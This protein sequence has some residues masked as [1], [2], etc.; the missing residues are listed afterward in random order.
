MFPLTC[1]PDSVIWPCRGGHGEGSGLGLLVLGHLCSVPWGSGSVLAN[2]SKQ[3]GNSCPWESRGQPCILHKKQDQFSAKERPE[4]KAFPYL[5]GTQLGKP[6]S[7]AFK[8][9][10]LILVSWGSYLWLL[11]ST[12]QFI[13]SPGDSLG[14]CCSIQ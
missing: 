12:L 2:L 9:V 5:P 3:R 8:I 6:C 14:L 1:S 11:L 10:P 7:P 13:H 4:G